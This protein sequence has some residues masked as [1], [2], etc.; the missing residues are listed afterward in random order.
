MISSVSSGEASRQIDISSFPRY[1]S[2]K[3]STS[4]I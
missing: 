4:T 3:S 1:L 2:E